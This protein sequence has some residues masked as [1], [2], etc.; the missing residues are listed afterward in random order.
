[1]DVLRVDDQ[2]RLFQRKAAGWFAFRFEGFVLHLEA[3]NL[4]NAKKILQVGLACGFKNSGIVVGKRFIVGIRGTI[5]LDS[6]ITKDGK[7][8]VSNEYVQ[9]LA[10]LSNSKFEENQKRIDSFHEGV[11]QLVIFSF[12]ILLF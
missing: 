11:N 2:R 4:E 6:P 7:Y 1:M 10:D 3:N 8:I 9:L 12:F 5:K